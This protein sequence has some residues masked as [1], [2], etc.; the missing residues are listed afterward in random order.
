VSKSDEPAAASCESGFELQSDNSC[1]DIDECAAS[2]TLCGKLEVCENTYGSFFCKRAPRE[3][4]NYPFEEENSKLHVD[5]TLFEV[6][7]DPMNKNGVHWKLDVPCASGYN[8]RLY[9][10]LPNDYNSA[11]DKVRF[12]LGW[13]GKPED[14]KIEETEEGV[15]ASGSRTGKFDSL[16]L[17]QEISATWMTFSFAG[18]EE[19]P[20]SGLNFPKIKVSIT[21]VL[22]D[23]CS[24]EPTSSYPSSCLSLIPGNKRT[25]ASVKYYKNSEIETSLSHLST[26]SAAGK[27]SIT[28]CLKQCA[29]T[30]GCLKAKYSL[31]RCELRGSDLANIDGKTFAIKG[32]QCSGTGYIWQNLNFEF[33]QIIEYTAPGNTAAQLVKNLKTQNPNFS[34]WSIDENGVTER[35][36]YRI[37]FE[38]MPT[39]SVH[40]DSAKTLTPGNLWVKFVIDFYI[41]QFT[42]T[43]LTTEIPLNK[44]GGRTGW[45]TNNRWRRQSAG[46]A[47]ITAADVSDKIVAQTAY[48]NLPSGVT[49]APLEPTQK[50][51]TA[52]PAA[53]TPSCQSGYEMA[54]DGTCADINECSKGTD[55]CSKSET[56]KNTDGSFSCEEKLHQKLLR[57]LLIQQWMTAMQQQQQPV[58]E[59]QA[60][61]SFLSPP[62]TSQ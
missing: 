19:T 13:E 7:L 12:G 39:P 38:E 18:F 48:M 4:E 25:D 29:L 45:W 28:E 24:A 36:S 27:E 44:S 42:N 46:S 53:N 62:I 3:I 33:E 57:I 49:Q 10:D 56:C 11:D 16:L 34:D 30:A 51:S 37:T 20:A 23:N 41:R 26:S 15:D 6:V 8:V 52:S 22:K 40:P 9:S 55:N 58:E 5:S 17:N 14:H 31:G 21:T 61:V 1:A 59:T 60:P 43:E 47:S 2:S 32:E 50:V 35:T 54:A